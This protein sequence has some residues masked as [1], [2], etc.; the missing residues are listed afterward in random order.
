MRFKFRNIYMYTILCGRADKRQNKNETGFYCSPEKSLHR[1]HS[2]PGWL[3]AMRTIIAEQIF[4]W[5][6]NS[7]CRLIAFIIPHDVQTK[8]QKM[9][10]YVWLSDDCIMTWSFSFFSPSN[11]IAP[12]EH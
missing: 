1:L 10:R 2:R 3:I 6:C 8:P 11:L 9:L 7:I 5:V 12:N 4:Y